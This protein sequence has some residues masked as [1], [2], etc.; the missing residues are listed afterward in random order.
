[1]WKGFNSSAIDD[2]FIEL[3][4]ELSE[5]HVSKSNAPEGEAIWKDVG[6]WSQ[7]Q[8]DL[9]VGKGLSSLSECL[10][11]PCGVYL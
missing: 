11:T 6:I 3:C 5:E 10:T 7:S 4:G 1:M 9:L 2:R 8:W